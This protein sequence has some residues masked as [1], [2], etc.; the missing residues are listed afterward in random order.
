E[1]ADLGQ[2]RGLGALADS[3]PPAHVGLGERAPVVLGLQ[4]VRVQGEG[5]LGRAGVLGVLDQLENEVGAVAVQ[6]A[7]QVQNRGVPAVPGDVLRADHAVVGG[8]CVL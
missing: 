8:H 7:Q 2:V 5:Q 4:P 3:A 1:A 6:V